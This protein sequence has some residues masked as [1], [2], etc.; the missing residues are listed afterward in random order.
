MS[1][2]E[3][4]YCELLRPKPI[5]KI[6][7]NLLRFMVPEEVHV[8]GATVVLNRMDPVISGA[9]TLR[10]FEKTE[11]RFFRRIYRPDMIFLDIGANVGYYTALALQISRG[12]AKVIALEPDPVS[13]EY[14]R[15]TVTRN[16]GTQTICLQRAAGHRRGQTILYRSGE[17]CGDNR[18]YPH[19]SC[20]DECYAE[21]ITVDELLAEL[22]IGEVDIIKMDVQGYEYHVL[23]GMIA[24][25]RRSSRLIIMME[26]WPHGLCQAGSDPLQL[27]ETLTECGLT[28][29]E[30]TAGADLTQ[31]RDRKAMINRYQGRRY[32]NLVATK[33]MELAA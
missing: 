15:K 29:F 18:L 21:I 11:T 27:L 10:V 14:L 30:L 1:L 6:T 17:N 25:V 16:G 9:L 32:T 3:F 7:N 26:F 31:V 24:T 33:G 8:H 12:C 28:L 22:D 19:E 2:S 5:K 20:T 4:I 23:S 13:F